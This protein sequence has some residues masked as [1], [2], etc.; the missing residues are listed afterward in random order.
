MNN[1]QHMAHT[2]S[3]HPNQCA[4]QSFGREERHLGVVGYCSLNSVMHKELVHAYR[5]LLA[6]LRKRPKFDFRTQRVSD[7]AAKKA[8]VDLYVLEHFRPVPLSFQCQN[9]NWLL[10]RNPIILQRGKDKALHGDNLT[11]APRILSAEQINR[12]PLIV[13][14]LAANG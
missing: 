7:C 14:L 4:D 12:L 8:R 6:Y 2:C 10:V 11:M 5:K 1:R 9:S 3:L 13:P